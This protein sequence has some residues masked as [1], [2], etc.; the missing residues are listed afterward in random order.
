MPPK[1]VYTYTAWHG[2]AW[3]GVA[4]GRSEQTI[5]MGRWMTGGQ[6]VVKREA[7]EVLDY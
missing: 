3:I 4:R 7:V 2:M 1:L 6:K 5:F